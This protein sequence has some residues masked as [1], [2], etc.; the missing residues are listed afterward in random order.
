METKKIVSSINGWL[1]K[2]LVRIA[3]IVGIPFI[4][5]FM[6]IVGIFEPIVYIITGFSLIDKTCAI[7]VIYDKWFNKKF[8]IKTLND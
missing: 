7:T 3:Y 6:V 2:L 1:I 5:A 4:V 8:G